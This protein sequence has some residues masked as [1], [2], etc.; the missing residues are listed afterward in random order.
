MAVTNS[1]GSECGLKLW[2]DLGVPMRDGVRLSADVFLPDRDGPFPTI[3]TRTPYESGRDAFLDVAAYWARRGFAFVVQDCRGRFESEGTFRAYADDPT[4]GYDTIEWVGGQ[5]W[6]NGKIGTWGRSYGG[7]TQ[8]LSAPLAHPQLTCMAPHVICDDFYSDCHYIGGAFQLMLSLGAAVI[9][10]TN[11]AT[12]VGPQSRHVFQNRRFW[13]HLPL[14]EMD[15]L[16]IGRRVEYWR[17]WLAHPTYGDYW[18]PFDIRG[19]HAE[20]TVPAFQQCGWFDPYTGSGFRNLNGMQQHGPNSRAREQQRILVGPWSHEEP[21]ATSMGGRDF[22]P[23]SLLDIRAEEHRWFDWQLK[24]IDDGIASEPPIRIFTMGAN[25]WRNEAEWPLERSVVTPLFLHST[26]RAGSSPDDGRLTLD[27]PGDEPVDRF[28]YDP[29]EPVPTL[30]GVLSVH[31]M[32]A[33]AEEPLEAGAVDQRLLEKR[34]D[35]LVY[36]TPVLAE[37]VEVTGP[38]SVVLYAESN[39]RDTDFTARLVDVAPDGTAFLVTEGILRARYRNGLKQTELLAPGVAEQ[40]EI[41]LYPTSIVFA[42][43]HRIR[44]DISSSNFPRFSRNLNTGEDVGTG[45]RMLV[46]ANSV[47]HSQATPSQLVLPVVDST[48]RFC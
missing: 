4:D 23:G 24:G 43:G 36:T 12:V 10:Q 27:P 5:G 19:R 47:L 21:V 16:A 45:T 1:P 15:E 26:G 14:I 9:W 17:E 20:I 28:H 32:T 35:V 39:A 31:M 29:A 18:K 22:G 48:L 13:S 37:P 30:G 38:V 34:D 25:S 11:L 2:H 8:W 33:H 7:L 46:A 42:A 44:L 41:V 3:V 6:C 40:M